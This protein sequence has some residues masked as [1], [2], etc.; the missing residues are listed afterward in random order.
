MRLPLLAVLILATS[1]LAAPDAGTPFTV[2][3]SHL[4]RA[5]RLPDGAWARLVKDTTTFTVSGPGGKAGTFSLELPRFTATDPRAKGVDALNRTLEDAC[6][7]GTSRQ[8]LVDELQEKGTASLTG[9]A[10]TVGLVKGPAVSVTVL[11]D[12]MGP[13]PST[14]RAVGLFDLAQGAPFTIAQALGAA[15]QK[16]FLALCDKALA[17]AR[18]RA[19]LGFGSQAEWEELARGFGPGVPG[20]FSGGCRWEWLAQPSRVELTAKG[21]LHLFMDLP[22]VAQAA[23]YDFTIPAQALAPLWDPKG[24]LGAA[25]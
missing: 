16:P 2:D 25:P 3:A 8:G 23:A 6:L 14:N 21:D 18:A 10:F 22:H 20:H 4:V 13:Y 17:E 9:C 24:P 1:A 7:A 15:H 5:V 11:A 12:S 19:R